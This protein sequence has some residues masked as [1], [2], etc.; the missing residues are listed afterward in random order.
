MN[1]KQVMLVICVKPQKTQVYKV[2]DTQLHTFESI[3]SHIIVLLT[4]WIS[5][6]TFKLQF[7]VPILVLFLSFDT[8]LTSQCSLDPVS[9]YH[10]YKGRDS[11]TF[12][13]MSHILKQQSPCLFV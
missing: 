12:D 2:S 10:M 8:D 11:K 7:S 6:V 9:I 5:K 13:V 3:N 4:D 1:T